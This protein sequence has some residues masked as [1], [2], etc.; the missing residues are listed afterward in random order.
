MVYLK[1]LYWV[2]NYLILL[3][4]ND[5]LNYENDEA[6]KLVLY[7]VETRTRLELNFAPVPEPPANSVTGTGTG[8]RLCHRYLY[9]YQALSPVWSWY[10][11]LSLELVP[12]RGSVTS[13][14]RLPEPVKV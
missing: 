9:R 7:A 12:V 4:I 13:T 1:T 11:A 10:Q 14:E 5:I 6:V 2:P 3:Y 8:T